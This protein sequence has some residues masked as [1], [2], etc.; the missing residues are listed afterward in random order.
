ME[1]FVLFKM[2]KTFPGLATSVLAKPVLH[3]CL[4]LDDL[5]SSLLFSSLLFSSLQQIFILLYISSSVENV[6]LFPA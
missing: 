5:F 3:L 6:S 4:L 2:V 1:N